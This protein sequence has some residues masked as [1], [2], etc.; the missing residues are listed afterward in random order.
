MRIT[1][2]VLTLIEQA[3]GM[4]LKKYKDAAGFPTVGIGHLLS[5]E[6]LASGEYNEI[7]QATA[8]K[9]LEADL[10]ESMSQ[11][12]S[13]VEVPINDNQF[14]ALVSFTFNLGAGALKRSTLL[15]KLNAGDYDGAANEFRRWTH[16]GPKGNK[17]KLEGLVRRRAQEELVFRSPVPV[18]QPDHEVWAGPPGDEHGIRFA[19]GHPGTVMIMVA[20]VVEEAYGTGAEGDGTDGEGEG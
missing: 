18:W 7:D 12:E 17:V 19:L 1:R 2:Q 10:R 14:S 5:K 11:V 16:A 6:E 13:L 15:S 4:E 8:Y 3:E 9:L 20:P